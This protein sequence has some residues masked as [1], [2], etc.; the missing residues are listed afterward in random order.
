[1]SGE[2]AEATRF[3]RTDAARIAKELK[4]EEAEEAARIVYEQFE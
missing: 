2:T 4:L 3:Q 1:M